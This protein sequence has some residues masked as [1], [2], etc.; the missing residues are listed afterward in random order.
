MKTLQLFS[1]PYGATGNIGENF[2]RL[3]GAPTLSPLQTVIREAVQNIADAAKLGRG[4]EI[5]LRVRTLS[6]EQQSVLAKVVLRQLPPEESSRAKLEQALGRPQLIVLEICDF[7]TTGL[8][9]PTRADRIPAGTERT[10]FIEFIRNIGTPRHTEH[11]GG[12][13]GFGKVALY[14]ASRCGTILVDSQPSDMGDEERRLIACHVG[15]SFSIPET[16]RQRMFTGRHWWGI[17]DESDGIVD[18][19]RGAESAEL[20]DALGMPC[21]SNRRS[22]TS[23]MILDFECEDSDL[24]VVGNRIAE[25]LLWNFWPRMMRDVPEDRRFACSIEVEGSRIALPAPEDLPPLHLFCEAMRSARS[26]LGPTVQAI[27]SLRPKKRLGTLSIAKGLRT[28]RRR[29]VSGSPLI[30]DLAH[31]IALMRPVELVVK[32]HEGGAIPDD[33]LEWAGVFIASDEDEVERAFVDAEPPA[34]D[35]WVPDSIPKGRARTFVNVALREIRRIASEMGE[36][37]SARTR[38]SGSIHPL[39]RLAGQLGSILA[40]VGGDG[41]RARR[42]GGNSRNAPRPQRARASQPI[43]RHLELDGTTRLA[44]FSTEV[45]QDGRRSGKTLVASA[46][47][48]VEGSELPLADS[49]VGRPAVLSLRSADGQT[50][51]GNRLALDGREG[52]FEIRVAVPENCAITASAVVLTE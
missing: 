47:V 42:P 23:I 36:I 35:D 17:A 14:R 29:L 51:P 6:P 38:G 3:L 30:P 16:G 25:T 15:R 24:R 21:R 49:E 44:V 5:L 13:Y 9:G 2:R 46:S 32:Y 19:L 26:R 52:S 22:G 4:P 50:F 8:G 31:H 33:R 39:A 37:P 7:G 1:E 40:D 20:A 12:T 10:D 41:A 48:V 45:V 11:G 43:F 27:E 28:G 18:P 34:H